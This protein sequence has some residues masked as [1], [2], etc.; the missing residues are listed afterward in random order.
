M[1]IWNV[2]CPS[3]PTLQTSQYFVQCHP[4]QLLKQLICQSSS[5][6]NLYPRVWHSQLSLLFL[7][8]YKKKTKSEFVILIVCFEILS[9]SLKDLAG[10]LHLSERVLLVQNIVSM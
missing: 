2:R 6:L 1:L 10:F 8:F 4:L 9:R 3:P 5:T 7:F